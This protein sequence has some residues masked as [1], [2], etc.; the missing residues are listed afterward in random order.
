LHAVDTTIFDSS[1]DE[2]IKN[3]VQLFIRALTP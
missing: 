2:I 1:L 3:S